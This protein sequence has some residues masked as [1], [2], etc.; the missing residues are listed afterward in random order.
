L[1]LIVLEGIDKAGKNTQARLLAENLRRDGK[2]VNCISF[3]DY[4]TPL[5]REIKRFLMGK[6]DFRPEV[7]QL[8]YVANR[9]EREGDISRWLREGNYVIADRYSQANLVY[10][11]ANGLDLNWMLALEEGLPKADSVVVLDI[12]P[13]VAVR[14]ERGK[15]VYE[16]DMEFQRR[17][18]SLYLELGEKLGWKV[19]NGMRDPKEVA[20][21][22][23]RLVEGTL[24]L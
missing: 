2:T 15:D 4:T 20:E 19:V 10:G 9:W 22:V 11:M 6:V 23:L 12:S 14:R 3:P 8:L 7:R 5:G 21:E 1:P 16:K 17:I 13:E 24:G 18:R